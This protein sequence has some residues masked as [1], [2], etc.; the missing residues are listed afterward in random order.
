MFKKIILFFVSRHGS[1]EYKV[2]T[3]RWIVLGI[4]VFYSASNSL[5]WIQF[6]IIAD[7]IQK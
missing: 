6:A 2:Y 7:V 1:G 4:F 5:Q 3:R